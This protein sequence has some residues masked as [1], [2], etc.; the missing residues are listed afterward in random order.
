MYMFNKFCL[1]TELSNSYIFFAHLGNIII[2]VLESNSGLS[3][4]V[5]TVYL[6]ILR[7]VSLLSNTCD[8]IIRHSYARVMSSDLPAGMK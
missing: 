2:L 6:S 4:R 7:V 1:V 5:R 3:G 8:N